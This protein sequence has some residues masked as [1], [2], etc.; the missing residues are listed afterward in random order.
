MG[1]ILIE[2]AFSIPVFLALIYYAHDLPKM[3]RWYRKMDFVSKQ[4]A[5]Y[6]QTISQTRA[7]KKITLMDLINAGRVAYLTIFPSGTLIPNKGFY[8]PWGY[9]VFYT[10]Y[11]VKGVDNNKASVIWAI[12]FAGDGG[13]IIGGGTGIKNG[14]WYRKST[15]KYEEI[16]RMVTKFLKNV[17]SSQIHSRLTIK[18]GE[19][20][21]IVECCLVYCTT[22]HFADG[23]LCSQKSFSEAF[24]LLFLSPEYH[25]QSDWYGFLN[26]VTIFT[27]RENLF[28][29]SMPQ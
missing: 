8:Y 27:P 15:V 11:Y 12:S 4:M 29:D 2:C 24:G 16:D 22:R 17:A 7:D 10:V 28:S 25:R 19:V 13:T 14:M 20:K 21:I 5:Q 23:T 3:K 1:A 18:Q 6:I 26:S 9:H